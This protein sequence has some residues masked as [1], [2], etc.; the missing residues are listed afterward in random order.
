[1]SLSAKTEFEK[2][3]LPE[4]QDRASLGRKSFLI[5][6]IVEKTGAVAA[7]LLPQGNKPEANKPTCRE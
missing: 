4:C 7:I 6:N 3:F 2:G 1:M 5:L